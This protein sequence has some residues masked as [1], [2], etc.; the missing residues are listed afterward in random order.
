MGTAASWGG[1]RAERAP[2]GTTQTRKIEKGRGKFRG[3][4]QVLEENANAK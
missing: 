4:A 1:C 3:R 2:R